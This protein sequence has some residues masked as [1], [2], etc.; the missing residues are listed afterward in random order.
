MTFA[1]DVRSTIFYQLN[2]CEELHFGKILSIWL[3]SFVMRGS[4]RD[5]S[6]K[7]K[8]L[9]AV[10]IPAWEP[11][12]QLSDL[13]KSLVENGISAVVIVDDGS[14]PESRPIFASMAA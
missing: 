2:P 13:A 8:P 14:N 6:T 7:D 9:V 3:I 4:E 10:L 11:E 1:L 12:A 5:S